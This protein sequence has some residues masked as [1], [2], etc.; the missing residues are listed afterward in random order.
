MAPPP[1]VEHEPTS[2]CRRHHSIADTSPLHCSVPFQAI[3]KVEL[4]WRL[5]AP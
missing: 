3:P 5:D 4:P 1:F 2:G